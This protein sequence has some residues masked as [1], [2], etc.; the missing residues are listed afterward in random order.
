MKM[1][2]MISKK[3][4][5]SFF[6]IFS[7]FQKNLFAMQELQLQKLV[8]VLKVIK[9]NT[10]GL[11]PQ[12][13]ASWGKAN[14]PFPSAPFQVTPNA[15]TGAV[16]ASQNNQAIN[17]QPSLQSVNV[18]LTDST[19]QNYL[20]FNF[21][22]TGKRLQALANNGLYVAINMTTVNGQNNA[23]IA[24]TNQQGAIVSQIT[25]P[26]PANIGF[27]YAN[28]GFNMSDTLSTP[29]VNAL[30]MATGTYVNWI[31][32]NNQQR[33][34]YQQNSALPTTAA[35]GGQTI[36]VLS[37]APS[38]SG[39]ASS[40]TQGLIPATGG[41]VPP[42]GLVAQRPASWGQANGPFPS[43][44]FVL[45]PNALTGAVYAS[46]NNQA[47][48]C[49][50]GLQSVNVGLTD[51]TGQNYLSFNFNTTGK[52]LQA[53]A[54]NGLYVAI[55]MTT[56]NGQN[57]AQIALTNQQGAIVSQI[58][59]PLPANI[60][61]MYANVGFNMS[62]TLSTPPVNAL[63]MA[64]GT[65]V[66]WIPINN[67][68]RIWYQQNFA[69]PTTTAIGAQTIPT[70]SQSPASWVYA[71]LAKCS[72]PFQ[73]T[74][75]A[76]TGPV[77][78]LQQ[79]Q[80]INCNGGLNF[81][82]VGLTDVAQQNWLY[83]KFDMSSQALKNL[84]SQGMY[85]AFNMQTQSTTNS[86]QVALTDQV[87]NVYSQITHNL[88]PNVGFA[89]A[90]VGWN[91]NHAGHTPFV[92]QTYAV[93]IPLGIFP[94][95]PRLW[96]QQS[97][98]PTSSPLG[99]LISLPIVQS[100]AVWANA[101]P[102]A[103]MCSAPFAVTANYLTGVNANSSALN[104][105]NGLSSV[106]VGLTDATQSNY[107]NFTFEIPVGGLLAQLAQYGLYVACGMFTATTGNGLNY[108]QVA[109]TDKFGNV[110]SAI[111]YQLPANV[112]FTQA[113]VGFNTAD[114]LAQPQ[115][116]NSAVQNNV[117][118]G[119][120]VWYQQLVATSQPAGAVAVTTPNNSGSTIPAGVGPVGF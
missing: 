55:N 58:T 109:L 35:I 98:N 6:I 14:G 31:P 54:N 39:A 30:G 56:V 7:L 114:T 50:T 9:N 79:G 103:S 66:N 84:A 111:D 74:P 76:L 117:P 18:G 60:G 51:A 48:N 69:L 78:S 23:Q 97:T 108:V 37:Q 88:E 3:V 17:C 59:F 13:P 12:S 2:S 67:Q 11:V 41:S 32:I 61:F 27:M 87:G 22:T 43:A 106:N 116:A 83:M 89:F 100:S 38:G 29:P 34:W 73:V 45:T 119:Q 95:Q 105:P 49:Q 99:T 68:Q 90:N 46:Q 62:D 33:I 104:C 5:W 8:K 81:L 44:P 77:Y 110:Y 75:N 16:Y 93:M 40:N 118:L 10:Q 101:V 85:V 94:Q 24:L 82:S 92:N 113:N 19:G 57:N 72:A 1:R 4:L 120:R 28:V 86:I 80:P 65:Y 71:S 36:P 26:L 107:L 20:S 96:Y 102:P 64:T 52:R 42:T 112:G 91:M 115:P 47:I 53:L 70:I 25:F 63:G 15:L 21:N